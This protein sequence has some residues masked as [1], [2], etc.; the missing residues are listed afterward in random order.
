[1]FEKENPMPLTLSGIWT[2]IMMIREKSPL[3][4]SITNFAGINTTTNALL[5]IGAFP[6]MAHAEQE[7]EDMIAVA[8]A[9]AIDIGAL[10]DHEVKSMFKAAESAKKRD[11]PIVIDPVGAGISSYRVRTVHELVTAASPTIIRGNPLDIMTLEGK[12]PEI[13]KPDADTVMGSALKAAGVLSRRNDGMV[14]CISGEIDYVV[15]GDDVMKV[16]HGHPLTARVAGMGCTAT[17]LCAAF[18]SVNDDYLIAT[19]RAMAV[20]GIAGE[21]AAE[22][23]A[24][25]GSMQV[26]FLDTLY[27]L[28]KVDIKR[29]L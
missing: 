13:K 4:H 27:R 11:I 26:N 9:L 12:K 29:F 14:I 6:I 20:M 16:R 3:I 18:A 19:A 15:R 21:I 5:A 28:S 22:A 25:G 23:S 8:D 2:D 10:N 7:I 1:M 24:G 17:A